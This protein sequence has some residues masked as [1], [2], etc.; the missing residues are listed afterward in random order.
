MSAAAADRKTAARGSA[1]RRLIVR[2]GLVLVYALLVALA[3]VTGK[4]HTILIDNKDRAEGPFQ[5]IDGILVTIDGREPLELYKGDRDMVKVKGQ[6]LRVT[7]E[8][9]AGGDK[10]TAELRI[11]MDVD[12][13]LLS[14]P[15]LAAGR[16]DCLEPFVT[17]EQP[18]EADE[19]V[20]NVNEFT[21]PDAAGAADGS[22]AGSAA[23]P[24]P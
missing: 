18:R 23:Q 4:S 10:E 24:A 3:F 21:S 14:V 6:K 17:S 20:G 22:A 15:M 5:A 2:S 16:E 9:I 12:M 7:L 8:P 11:P 1:T 13:L 19:T